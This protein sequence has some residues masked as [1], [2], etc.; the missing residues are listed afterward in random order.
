MTTAF[1]TA[2]TIP[3]ET[4][5]YVHLLCKVEMM[6]EAI[7]DSAVTGVSGGSKEDV[8]TGG[9]EASVETERIMAVSSLLR[10]ETEQTAPKDFC[11]PTVISHVGGRVL[12]PL[13]KV[14]EGRHFIDERQ[15]FYVQDGNHVQDMSFKTKAT[16]FTYSLVVETPDLS[17]SQD[18]STFPP[19]P[20]GFDDIVRGFP[21]EY[22]DKE[23]ETWSCLAS[24]IN[25]SCHL[26]EDLKYVEDSNLL[27]SYA[28][29]HGLD[30]ESVYRMNLWSTSLEALATQDVNPTVTDSNA[31]VV[32]K[33]SNFL[34]QNL[35]GLS[36]FAPETF[37]A[38][39][40]MTGTL[41][42]SPPVIP[43]AL[44]VVSKESSDL[45]ENIAS[46]FSGI[47]DSVAKL[48]DRADDSVA[49]LFDAWKLSLSDGKSAVTKTYDS[50]VSSLFS[51]FDNSK[52][53]TTSQSTG[54]SF[55]LDKNISKAGAVVIDILRWTIIGVEEAISKSVTF[56]VY[57]YAS[58][59]AFLPPD[60]RNILNMFEDE[61]T[62][63]LSPIEAALQQVYKA[64]EGIE[65][66][67]G[68]DPNDPLVPFLLLFGT[69]TTIGI[70]YWFFTYNGYSLNL[71]CKL[72]LVMLR[73][74]GKTVVSISL[75]TPKFVG[76]YALGMSLHVVNT[77]NTLWTMAIKE[78]D[79][80]PDLRREARFKY[81]SVDLLEI[82]NSVRKQLK[83]EKDVENGLIAVVIQNLKIIKESYLVEGGFQRWRGRGLRFKE[84]KSETAL[85]ILNEEVEAIF[86]DIKPSPVQLVGYGLG[87]LV[88]IYALLEWEKTLQ[89]IGIVG[90]G[91]ALYRHVASYE[92]SEDLK[93]DVRLLLA[94]VTLG[95]NA[96]YWVT[97]KLEPKIIRLPTAPSSTAVQ[98]R[99]LQAAAKHESQ[100]SDPDLS[101]GQAG[102][103]A[104]Q[105]NER[106]DPPEA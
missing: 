32:V 29:N 89:L 47:E 8:G 73:E 52:G 78:R 102:D 80:I 49:T 50:A 74:G 20:N 85:T 42:G 58:A 97:G 72:H 3:N 54:F 69:T 45:K 28:Q 38:S 106:T 71:L 2:V 10:V 70:S 82:N 37:S 30:S 62:Q 24:D 92:N 39:D 84:P 76:P 99:V 65:R 105:A 25:S 14:S 66:N 101:Q 96:I 63:S 36:T 95:A 91:Q 6:I 48:L 98:D 87:A 40:A 12:Y 51:F 43:G 19:F 9:G 83:R 11:L 100:P 81:A 79:G 7:F 77:F 44:E 53:Q 94:P 56:V 34:G 17:S 55:N 21:N 46:F 22:V 61:V 88:A 59:K 4:I 67:L 104:G 75:Q 90:I 41:P 18:H 16:Q 27:G 5:V 33:I 1:T 86:E 23:H 15:G 103:S 57:N 93:R 13:R 64:I 68:L 35:N 26:F 31:E 60:I